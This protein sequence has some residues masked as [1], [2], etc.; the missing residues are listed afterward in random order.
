MTDMGKI[1]LTFAVGTIVSMAVNVGVNQASMS[2]FRT[3]FEK[4]EQRSYKKNEK[5]DDR[6]NRL[7]IAQAK[8]ENKSA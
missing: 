8:I 7:E 5:Q 4:F 3:S 2:E 6:L 1:L